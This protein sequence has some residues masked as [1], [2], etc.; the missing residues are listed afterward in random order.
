M[1]AYLWEYVYENIFMCMTTIFMRAYLRECIY[2]IISTGL[3]LWDYMHDE[4]IS[5]SVFMRVYFWECMYDEYSYV[6][7]F[8]R[9][10]LRAYIESRLMRVFVWRL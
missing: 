10:Y 8:M 9:V 3:F 5:E 1:R 6:T 4:Y 2:E 7:V